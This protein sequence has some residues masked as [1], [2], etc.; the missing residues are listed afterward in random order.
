MFHLTRQLHRRKNQYY[1]QSIP[2]V[3]K[4][5]GDIDPA[6]FVSGF[7]FQLVCFMKEIDGSMKMN[8]KIF[9]KK[10]RVVFMKKTGGNGL[11]SLSFGLVFA[12]R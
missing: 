9:S 3:A 11:I 6:V 2:A 1:N 4:Q 7:E 8:V 12:I 10:G 5:H